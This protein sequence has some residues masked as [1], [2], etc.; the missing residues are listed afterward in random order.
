MDRRQFINYIDGNYF[1][2]DGNTKI[3]ICGTMN[4]FLKHM[5]ESQHT[6][7]YNFYYDNDQIAITFTYKNGLLDGPLTRYLSTGAI[8]SIEFCKGDEFFGEQIYYGLDG[9]IVY[10]SFIDVNGSISELYE[11]YSYTTRTPEDEATLTLAF[12][13]YFLR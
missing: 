13:E 9:K 11:K 6:G 8:C 12:G 2:K 3:G 1:V 5:Y 4:G 7:E 10:N